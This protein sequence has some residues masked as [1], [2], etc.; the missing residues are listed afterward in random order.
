MEAS[1]SRLHPKRVPVTAVVAFVL[2]VLA[3]ISAGV[4]L[5]ILAASGI[6]GFYTTGEIVTFLASLAAMAV[7]LITSTAIGIAA[8]KRRGPLPSWNG[9][10]LVRCLAL[11]AALA[12]SLAAALLDLGGDAIT[13]IVDVSAVALVVNAVRWDV[14]IWRALNARSD[15]T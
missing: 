7:L 8:L 3:G 14:A 12:T 10:Y 9:T 2:A 1:T 4:S 6:S 11:V 13:L 5:L 15:G